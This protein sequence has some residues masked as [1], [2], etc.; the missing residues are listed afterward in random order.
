MNLSPVWKKRAAWLAWGIPVLGVLE[1]VLHLVFAQ[2]A[3]STDEWS[4]AAKVLEPLRK[5]DDLVIVA[6]WWAEPHARQA[7][8]PKLLPIRDVARADEAPYPRAIELSAMGQ[9]P[10]EIASWPIV[11]RYPI[12]S[13][14]VA[15]VRRNPNPAK[16]TVNFSD[17]VENAQAKVAWNI[18]GIETPCSF[19]SNMPVS[20][21][22]LFG[23]P[24]IPPQRYVC[25]RQPWQA[26]GVTVHD[27]QNFRA[28]RCVWSH[29]PP[30]SGKVVLRFSQVPLANVI[31]GYLSLHWTLE[32]EQHGSPVLFALFVDDKA[33][34]THVHHDGQGWRA[35]EIALGSVANGTHDVR[36]EISS[37]NANERHV[38]W[39]ADS[40]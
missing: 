18:A 3:P 28:R 27:D 35:F 7:L 4:Q 16:V 39:T 23:H 15:L 38:C 24:A 10:P 6:P 8:G 11:E 37:E 14:L 5:A 1:L 20:A 9:H 31:H 30:P 13:H 33:I 25:G 34:G 22:G 17:L 36:I 32:R 2:R 12:S 29:P 26:V 19:S 40:R 21:P